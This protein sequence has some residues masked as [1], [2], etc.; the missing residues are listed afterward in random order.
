[1]L[2]AALL[3]TYGV[4][5]A[6]AVADPRSLLPGDAGG[7][8]LLAAQVLAPML[9]LSLVPLRWPGL[10]GAVA[11]ALLIPWGWMHA[12][13]WVHVGWQQGLVC[14]LTI[15]V[16]ALLG[17]MASPV[18]ALAWLSVLLTA[19]PE[20]L[21]PL[22]PVGD[23]PD[24]PP[25]VLI[26]L[27]TFRADHVGRTGEAPYA[28]LT[29][30]LDALAD[31]GVLFTEGVAPAPVT[32][33]SHAGLLTGRFPPSVGVRRNGER[34]ADDAST[35]AEELHA[36]GWRT[37]AFTAS[38]VLDRR[39]GLGRGFVHYDDRFGPAHYLRA[40]PPM[41][42]LGRYR[43]LPRHGQRDGDEVI[44]RALRWLGDDPRGTL[45]WVH[46]YDAHSPYE[47]E[48][49]PATLYAYDPDRGSKEAVK[50]WQ[51]W[52]NYWYQ[53]RTL[54]GL[55][56]RKPPA[57]E[58]A[59]YAAEIHEV[60]ARV[61]RLVAALPDDVRLVVASD[62]GE[63]LIE[64]GYVMNHGRHVF[65]ATTRVPLWVVAPGVP[66]GEVVDDPVPS[67]LVG[68]ELRRL[69]GLPAERP[70]T[71]TLQQPYT[72]P[73]ES[74]TSGQEARPG[75]LL[76]QADD[77]LAVRDGLD[78]Y[79]TGPTGTLWFDVLTD[80]DQRFPERV[81]DDLDAQERLRVLSEGPELDEATEQ[82]LEALGYTE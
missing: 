42:L 48:L 80:S 59:A 78:T 18:V 51:R 74:Y 13:P 25:V 49:D 2:P 36:A 72:E 33:P 79:V 10:L 1:V 71:S 68:D 15:S 28:A 60:D 34:L 19:R 12:L 21:A 70:L 35:V 7:V 57:A 29:P 3:T 27:D 39:V 16:G 11:G 75:F 55:G 67:W 40:L 32:V 41:Q 58:M 69:A 54:P 63:S 26:T 38:G 76:G 46:L 56:P 73:I 82:W 62:H 45:L 23:R 5:V 24:A 17:R 77:E 52:R 20:P 31:R 30:H 64:H 6:W 66:A 22:A 43:W 8:V 14:V 9:V 37:G 47:P 81:S 53:V 50:R 61:G 65:R 44:E 4:V